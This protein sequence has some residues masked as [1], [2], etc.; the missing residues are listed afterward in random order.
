M[1]DAGAE[2]EM[3]RTSGA[4]EAVE[5]EIAGIVPFA[6]IMVGRLVPDH[7]LVAGTDR[8][9]AEDDVLRSRSPHVLGH[10]HPPQQ[11]FHGQVGI[12]GAIAQRRPE[13]R[14]AGQGQH[15]PRDRVLRHLRRSDEE[16]AEI[17]PQHLL[18]ER[19]AVEAAAPHGIDKI[20]PGWLFRPVQQHL[21]IGVD[22]EQRPRPGRRRI[23]PIVVGVDDAGVARQHDAIV[24]GDIEQ[25]GQEA[26]DHGKRDVGDDFAAADG[27][28]PRNQIMGLFPGEQGVGRRSLLAEERVE[29]T[30]QVAMIGRIQRQHGR[31]RLRRGLFDIEDADAAM[32]KVGR[33][34]VGGLEHG[35]DV[36]IAGHRPEAGSVVFLVPVDRIVPPQVGVD[37]VQVGREMLVGIL[38]VDRLARAGLGLPAAKQV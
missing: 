22:L 14:E 18:V 16:G 17:D 29:R 11:F 1:M 28:D 20:W 3:A 15:H 34:Y 7:D 12:R 32:A 31:A 9:A 33:E 37:G 26:A 5:A 36:V 4:G 10:A 35:D 2:C 24:V 21:Q 27:R 38:Q 6:V 19:S 30:P 8:L 25:K 13:R 23:F